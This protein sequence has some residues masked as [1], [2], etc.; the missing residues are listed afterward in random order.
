PLDHTSTRD[1]DV[2]RVGPRHE[3]ESSSD[4]PAGI[5]EQRSTECRRLD[6]RPGERM[7]AGLLEQQHGVDEAQA[8]AARAFGNEQADDPDVDELLPEPG[9]APGVVGPRLADVTRRAL[10]REQVTKRVAERELVVGEREPHRQRLGS[11]R[12][13]SAMTL[14]WISL[15][16]A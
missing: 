7:T 6:D 4:H 3:L 13:R 15:V 16:P 14:R 12:T 9:H 5:A 10:L 8:Q 2:R 1:D 11:P